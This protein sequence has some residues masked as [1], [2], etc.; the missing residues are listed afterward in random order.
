MAIDT[1]G[2]YKRAKEAFEQKFMPVYQGKNFTSEDVY[3]FFS[4]DRKP[5]AV[6]FKRVLGQVLYELSQRNKSRQLEQ[7]GRYYRIINRTLNEIEWWNA[8][9]GDIFPFV[10]PYGV[11]DNTSF[12]FDENIVIYPKDLIVIAGEGNSAKT[13]I[14]LNMV[15][16]NMDAY[17]IY[18]FSSEF[19]APKF[20]DRMSHF[21]WV[22]IYDA[23]GKPKFILA[24]HTHHWQ[25]V[26]QPNAIN[27]IDWIYLADETWKIRDIMKSVV[28]SL[29]RGIAVIV[30]Q[31][32]SYKTVG[33]GGEATKDLA[34]V[35][36][37]IRN[38]KELRQPILKV[39]KVK[40]PGIN[41]PNF[42]QY[43]FRVVQSGSKL[44]DIQELDSGT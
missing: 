1:T 19:N 4:V 20:A 10:W 17:P 12:G 31:K 18:Y 30:L 36:F 26:I 24:E 6:E 25:D 14:C 29:D 5:N 11:E 3:H 8:K 40:T 43:S 16:N 44:H 22:D 21:D 23:K 37:T 41:N 39:E 38:D 35:Y 32:R 9:R 15:V 28:A 33:E 34:S 2:L 7:T 13:T 27:I 42:K